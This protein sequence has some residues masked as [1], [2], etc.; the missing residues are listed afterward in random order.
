MAGRTPLLLLF[1]LGAWAQ[2]APV[3]ARPNAVEIVLERQ[4]NGD[5]RSIDPGLV[6]DA[7]DLVR[8]RFRSNFDGY[9]YVINAG[10]SGTESLLFP[11]DATG[12]NNQVAAGKDYFVPST[13]A[14]FRVAGPPGHDIVYWLISPLP[15][16]GNPVAGPAQPEKRPGGQLIPRCDDSIFRARGLCIDSS[17]GPRNVR[18]GESLPAGISSIPNLAPRELVITEDQNKSRVSTPP[19]F[20]GPVVYEFRVAHR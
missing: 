11:G 4:T 2:P 8:F 18:E 1:S 17:A 12:R 9:L 5:W 7:G 19:A 13:S 16:P 3:A 14:S 15:L 20:R 6:L 10:T